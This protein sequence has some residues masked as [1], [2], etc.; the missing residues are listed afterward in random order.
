MVTTSLN[1]QGHEVKA[2]SRS[3]LV[4]E[5]V[6]CHFLDDKAVEG[7]GSVLRAVSREEP[8]C[9]RIH[10]FASLE[11]L[12]EEFSQQNTASGSQG[13][14]TRDESVTK[15]GKTRENLS[16]IRLDYEEIYVFLNKNFRLVF[17]N[18][19]DFSSFHLFNKVIL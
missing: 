10:V 11:G 1:I 3:L 16:I 8:F 14:R 12:E 9:Q 4:F 18:S 17:T 13:K 5:K 7:L 6:S 2:F 19:S 15:P